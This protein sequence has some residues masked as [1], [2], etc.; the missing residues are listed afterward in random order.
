MMD[1]GQIMRRYKIDSM[2]HDQRMNG[3]VTGYNMND[4]N[5]QYSVSPPSSKNGEEEISSVT[6]P[7][8]RRSR[9]DKDLPH[10]ILRKE[11]ME[12]RPPFVVSYMR[13]QV[14][15]RHRFSSQREPLSPLIFRSPTVLFDV[16]FRSEL[17]GR[18]IINFL[19]PWGRELGPVM[20]RRETEEY[21]EVRSF[22]IRCLSQH[23]LIYFD[24]NRANTIF[25]EFYFNGNELINLLGIALMNNSNGLIQK[26]NGLSDHRES[27]AS[28]ESEEGEENLE[29]SQT[30]Y[31]PA[32]LRSI[33]DP[34]ATLVAVANDQFPPIFTNSA[35]DDDNNW[36]R[37]AAIVLANLSSEA[38]MLTIYRLGLLLAR[39]NRNCAADFCLLV[40]CILTGYDCFSLPATSQ[41]DEQERSREHIG[42]VHSGSSLLNRID[43]LSGIAGFAFTDLHATDIFVYALR[44]GNNKFQKCEFISSLERYERIM[45]MDV[46]AKPFAKTMKVNALMKIKRMEIN[47]VLRYI[48]RNFIPDKEVAEKIEKRLFGLKELIKEQMMK[49]F[50]ED[51]NEEEYLDRLEK[52]SDEERK[53]IVDSYHV[54]FKFDALSDENDAVALKLDMDK[55]NSDNNPESMDAT[56]SSGDGDQQPPCDLDRVG[57]FFREELSEKALEVYPVCDERYGETLDDRGKQMNSEEVRKMGFVRVLDNLA[58]TLCSPHRVNYDSTGK[59]KKVELTFVHELNSESSHQGFTDVQISDVTPS[60]FKSHGFNKIPGMGRSIQVSTIGKKVLNSVVI[61]PKD[62][63]EKETETEINQHVEAMKRFYSFETIDITVNTEENQPPPVQDEPMEVDENELRINVNVGQLHPEYNTLTE[64]T[65]ILPLRHGELVV[66]GKF[67]SSQ[68]GGVLSRIMR[69]VSSYPHQHSDLKDLFAVNSSIDGKSDVSIDRIIVHP[70]TELVAFLHDESSK[71]TLGDL[72]PEAPPENLEGKIVRK[73][74]RD[75]QRRRERYR[76]K[77]GNISFSDVQ[78]DVL[79]QESLDSGRDMTDDEIEDDDYEYEDEGEIEGIVDPPPQPVQNNEENEQNVEH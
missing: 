1:Y 63:I 66:I 16:L 7:R 19:D 76:E 22:H 73:N 2:K 38:A 60:F 23:T 39:R 24:G 13:Y 68:E 29:V 45:E 15:P 78:Y 42:L 25:I 77:M 6:M 31:M 41:S 43:G 17:H 3:G 30:L 71:I 59:N 67:K 28:D 55:D 53:K 64:Y 57:S 56:T 36:K 21:P 34:F 40:V 58:K 52:L 37:H 44:L 51:F 9:L 75:Y 20:R 12:L 33:D 14:R 11:N 8:P 49:D 65:Q 61:V 62:D 10:T 32:T 69:S 5:Q 50:E 72:K 47:K 74:F 35:F 79:V 70:T 18:Y 27:V 4:W 54:K 26:R 48:V 46:F